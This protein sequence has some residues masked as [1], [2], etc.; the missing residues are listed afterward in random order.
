M[1][2]AINLSFYELFAHPDLGGNFPN[3]TKETHNDCFDQ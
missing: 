1:Q 3:H 2:S